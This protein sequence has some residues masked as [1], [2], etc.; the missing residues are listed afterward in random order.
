L[1]KT[2]VVLSRMAYSRMNHGI[3]AISL[4]MMCEASAKCHFVDWCS[5]KCHGA[6]I[7]GRHYTE[8]HSTA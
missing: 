4:V 3:V 5:T 7:N 8:W 2:I 6:F 1:I